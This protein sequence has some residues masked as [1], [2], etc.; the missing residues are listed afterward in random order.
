MTRE[1]LL[2]KQQ[3]VMKAIEDV[4]NGAQE[5]QVGELRLR[6]P[7]LKQLY[8]LLFELDKQLAQCEAYNTRVFVRYGD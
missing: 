1:E 2:I 4:L 8:Q 6:K 3:Q 5:V 7:D